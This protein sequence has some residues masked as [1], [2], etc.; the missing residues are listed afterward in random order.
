MLNSV[1]SN[2]FWLVPLDFLCKQ[3]YHLQI[4]PLLLLTLVSFI[5]FSYLITVAR[6]YNQM[7]NGSSETY[8][9]SL[10]P[11]SGGKTYY[12]IIQNEIICKIF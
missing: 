4:T 5:S 10:I 8:I 12:S 7:L 2:N 6:T 3:L 11:A 9:F 1:I